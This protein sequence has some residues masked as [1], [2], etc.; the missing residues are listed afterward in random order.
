MAPNARTP[1]VFMA[2]AAY[3]KFRALCMIPKKGG[4]QNYIGPWHPS[5]SRALALI[6]KK[7]GAAKLLSGPVNPS[8][9]SCSLCLRFQKK[10]KRGGKLVSRHGFE[11]HHPGFA[12][13]PKKT[14][15]GKFPDAACFALIPK[16]RGA[17]QTNAKRIAQPH[18]LIWDL[19][20]KKTRGRQNCTVFSCIV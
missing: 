1:P 13:I 5:P 20:P 17:G 14:G 15:G 2:Q 10:N 18:C 9:F 16:N 7:R 3:A 19:I 11:L 12:L 8:V 4:R 6:P